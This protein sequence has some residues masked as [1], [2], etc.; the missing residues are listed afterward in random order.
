MTPEYRLKRK[1]M[2]WRWGVEIREI[3]A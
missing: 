2:L 3:R 1:L